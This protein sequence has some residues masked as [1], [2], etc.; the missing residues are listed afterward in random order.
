MADVTKPHR[1]LLT[2]KIEVHDV[3]PTGEFSGQPVDLKTQSEYGVKGVSRIQI[4]GYDLDNCL[5]KV[6]EALERLKG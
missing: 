5:R 1:A 6:K 2:I 4:E 3:L